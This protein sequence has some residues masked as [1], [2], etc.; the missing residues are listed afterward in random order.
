[1]A[2]R[3]GPD[4]APMRRIGPLYWGP[5]RNVWWVGA[6][7]MVGSACFMAGPVVGATNNPVA[8]AVIYFVGSIFFTSAAYLQYAEVA[9]DAPTNNATGSSPRRRVRALH[10]EPSRIEWQAAVVQLA[11]TVMFNISTFIAINQSLDLKRAERLVWTPDAL[12][13]FCFLVASYLA[14]A[15]AR[16]GW[17]RGRTGARAHGVSRWIAWLNFAGSVAF[18]ISAIASYIVPDTGEL[19]DAAASSSW[20]FI[21]AACFFF[22]AYLLWPESEQGAAPDVA[23]DP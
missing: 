9:K 19:L 4:D 8:A 18:G 22:A 2:A 11:G 6:L 5:R 23:S 21:G 15:E 10:F 17:L 13:S 20:T 3:F 14:L 7:F 12:G 1:M 16:G